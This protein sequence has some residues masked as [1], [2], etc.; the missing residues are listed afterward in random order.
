ME[1]HEAIEI[2]V[3]IRNKSRSAGQGTLTVTGMQNGAQVYQ[4]SHDIALQARE[5]RQ[6]VFPSYTPTASGDIFWTATLVSG[7]TTEVLQR[8]TKVEMEAEIEDEHEEDD[9]DGKDDDHDDDD[10][11]GESHG[12]LWW[13]IPR[14]Y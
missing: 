8:T 1:E 14:I 4:V 2:S 12:F 7:N 9:K 10:D 5:T 6:F 13:I 11:E 3:S